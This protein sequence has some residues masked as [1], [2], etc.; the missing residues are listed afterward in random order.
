[1]AIWLFFIASLVG[2]ISLL[3]LINQKG[4]LRM[5][6]VFAG[7]CVLWWIGCQLGGLSTAEG[8]TVGFLV[9][10]IWILNFISALAF[11]LHSL[12]GDGSFWATALTL[13]LLVVVA[14]FRHRHNLDANANGKHGPGPSTSF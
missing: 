11:S 1:V 4:E 9:L 5:A 10:G 6:C 8:E 13:A 7:A 12:I 3:D 2:N 14:R